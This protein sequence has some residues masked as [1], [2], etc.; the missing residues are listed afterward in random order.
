[1][2]W[3]REVEG[4]IPETSG[5]TAPLTAAFGL[6]SWNLV[7]LPPGS[8]F[9]VCRDTAA[10]FEGRHVHVDTPSRSVER[11]AAPANPA[12]KIPSGEENSPQETIG[13]PWGETGGTCRYSAISGAREPA[14]EDPEATEPSSPT[15][16]I[17]PRVPRIRRRNVFIRTVRLLLVSPRESE[18]SQPEGGL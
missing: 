17:P 3:E 9:P 7:C 5:G 11:V 14:G 15:V 18:R 2:Q 16:G 10:F 6:R 1:M 8:P 13:R 4:L 12:G